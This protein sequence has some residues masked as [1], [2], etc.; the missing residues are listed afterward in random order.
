MADKNITLKKQLIKEAIII[1]VVL[2]LL[3]GGGI[4]LSNYDDDSLAE[5][6]T[7]ENKN[8]TMQGEQDSIQKE[9]G[10]SFE[11]SQFYSLYIKNHNENFLLNRELATQWMAS[12]R[13]ANHLSNLS[14]SIS[15]ITDV[16]PDFTQLKSGIMTK[17]EVHLTFNTISDS[18]IYGFMESL[19]R[20]L[21]GI[22]AFKE[23]KFTHNMSYTG[24]VAQE[25]QQHKIPP[26]VNCDLTFYWLGIRPPTDNKA[27]S[28]A[29]GTP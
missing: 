6:Q 24:N 23:I 27:G 4:M 13:E 19:E 14:V 12:L 15:P 1:G 9:L 22:V 21:P 25:L 2:V 26:L 16:T 28:H 11:V 8:A 10:I 5:K 20:T 29:G 17:S 7:E 18:S 3:G